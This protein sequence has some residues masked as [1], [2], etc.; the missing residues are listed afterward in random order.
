LAE[1]ILPKRGAKSAIFAAALFM[2]VGVPR[3]RDAFNKT[4]LPFI[5]PKSVADVQNRNWFRP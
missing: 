2:L 3:I 4:V 5:D 1:V